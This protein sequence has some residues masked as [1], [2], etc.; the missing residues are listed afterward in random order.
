[1]F[2]KCVGSSVFVLSFS[3]RSLVGKFVI[4]SKQRA[5]ERI[6]FVATAVYAL[7]DSFSGPKDSFLCP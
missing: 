4:G 6:I 1:M 3:F 2:Q 5:F 7:T